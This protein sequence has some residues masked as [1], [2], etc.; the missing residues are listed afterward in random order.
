MTIIASNH[1]DAWRLAS[2][3]TSANYSYN[4]YKSIRA[5]YPVYE[6]SSDEGQDY[7]CDLGCRL[8]V[9]LHKPYETI[10]IYIKE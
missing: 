10:N 9:N 7:I 8:E 5:G 1:Q 6:S 3:F 4:C 2:M